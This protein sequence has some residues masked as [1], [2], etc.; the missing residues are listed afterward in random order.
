MK[1]LKLIVPLIFI[2]LLLASCEDDIFGPRP[3]AGTWKATEYDKD[4][5]KIV[6]SVDIN[7]LTGESNRILIRNF[8]SLGNNYE[9]EATVSG[10]TLTVPGQDVSGGGGGS[11]FKVSGSGKAASNNRKIDWSYNV[12][13]ENFT[14]VYEK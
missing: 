5:N 11:V 4:Q 6:F 2:F 14:A 9:V 8:A 12:D 10:L 1:K 7:Y 13:G 3:F